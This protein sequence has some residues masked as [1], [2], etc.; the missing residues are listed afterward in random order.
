[1]RF[2]VIMPVYNS[3]KTL[4]ESIA[5]VL[6][7]TCTDFEL[8]LVDDGSTDG[9]AVMCDSAAREDPRVRVI[10]QT[11]C[12]Q[13]RTRLNGIAASKGEYC[14]FLDSDDLYTP[15]NLEK[16]EESIVAFHEP[17]LLIRSFYYEYP[18]GSLKA[19]P[20]LFDSPVLFE[21]DD[22]KTVLSCFFTGTMLN[23]VWTKAVKRT[24]FEGSFPDY[25]RFSELLVAEDRLHSM[26]MADNAGRIVYLPERCC[27]YRTLPG[28]VTRDY[29]PENALRFCT[30]AIY[31]EE[32]AYIER[33]GLPVPETV[34]R[35]NAQYAAGAIYV[36]DRFYRNA[37]SS[38][39]RTAL[40]ALPWR[41][42]LPEPCIESLSAN[43][44][45]NEAQIA[46]T[47]MILRA[48]GAGLMHYYL[49]KRTR[50]WLKMLKNRWTSHG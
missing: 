30:K 41:S 22:R 25:A 43:P 13:L 8:I 17:D 24:V 37:A 15:D 16:L 29:R 35:L 40:I 49:Q 14:V 10:H 36:F 4:R 33:W 47:K 1:M 44:F 7:Q 23:S 48:D 46:L 11:N 31:P 5:S 39:D 2:S 27:R 3:E 34:Q 21:G 32:L 18:D 45:L 6:S 42:F 12:R 28:S 26:G 50:D 38:A 19:A 9:S 20:F